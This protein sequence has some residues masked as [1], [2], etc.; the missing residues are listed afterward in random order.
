MAQEH[1][2]PWCWACGRGIHDRPEWWHAPWIIHRAHLVNKPRAKDVRA[3][4]LL[5]PVCHG[6][7]HG[8]R[9]ADCD[10]PALE[11]HHLLWIK[12]NRD[13][14]YYDRKFLQR[15]AVRLLPKVKPPPQ[16]YLLAY[17]HRRG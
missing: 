5:C 8:E 13:R 15:H 17:S 12:L 16:V 6:L 1:P 3:V 7:S 14:V 4:V 9:Y 11:L 10:L 2:L